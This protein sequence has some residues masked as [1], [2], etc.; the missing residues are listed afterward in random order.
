M[1]SREKHFL[2]SLL[3]AVLSDEASSSLGT[4]GR[5]DL[6]IISLAS[7]SLAGVTALESSSDM[8]ILILPS[9]DFCVLRNSTILFVQALF[10]SG[11]SS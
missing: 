4:L 3:T 10:M 2:Q 7:E 5:E 6:E 1:E 11:L 8:L 9:I